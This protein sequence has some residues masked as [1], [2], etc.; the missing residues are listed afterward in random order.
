MDDKTQQSESKQN[1]NDEEVA[2]KRQDPNPSSGG[3]GFSPLSFLSDLQKAAAVAAEEISRNAAV[4]AETASK[5]I[6][7]LQNEDEDSE[8]EYE[9][10]EGSAAEKESDDEG[11]KL[12]KSALERLEKASE[13]SLLSQGLKVFD[14]SVE[15]FASGAW[16]A[17]GNAWRGGTD[18]VQRLENSAT[19]LSGSPKHD[20]PGAAGANASSLLETGKAFT[21]KGMQVLEYVGKET[22]D[23]LISET[24]IEVEKDKKEGEE[25]NDED[26]LSEEVTFDRCFYIYG[27]PEQLEEL[28]AL[29]SHYALLFNRRK[30]KLSAEQKSVYDGKLKE[31]QQVFNLSTDIG[32]SNA[33]SNKG[34]TIKK[35]N[36]GSSDEMK[37]L[38]DSSVGKAAEMAA[39]FTNALAGLAANDI[40][41]RTTARLE[42][43]HS[44]GVHRLSE[45]CCFVVSQLLVLGK[46]IISRANNTEDE[47]DDDK[48]NIEWPE[49]VSAKANIIRINAQKMIGYVEAV[50]NSFITGISDVTEAYQA[51]IKAVTAES[52]SVVTQKSV[53]EK[54]TAFSEHLRAEQTTAVCKI[55]DGMQ[56]LAHV[57]IST[58][59]NAA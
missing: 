14:N 40:H 20:G 53:Q 36:E 30:A 16:S 58:S 13:E 1:D 54:A 39:G 21:A 37:N 51:A 26:Q 46:S 9:G 34:K 48:A 52:H 59:M 8:K 35:G 38:H 29:S 4:V 6:A 3:W 22:M 49:D 41:Q 57:L 11:S 44:E 56:F 12:R 31:V 28:E 27:G 5:S 33:D 7:E 17:L 24:G 10:D 2:P 43:L 55:Q 18:F 15:T 45:M 25:E 47:A 42:S 23:L 19:N 32:R 50:S